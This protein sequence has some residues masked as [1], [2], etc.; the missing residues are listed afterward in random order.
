MKYNN[1]ITEFYRPIKVNSPYM[2]I[3]MIRRILLCFLVLMSFLLPLDRESFK[4]RR[5]NIRNQLGPRSAMVLLTSDIYPRNNDVDFPFRPDSDFWYVTGHPEPDAKLIMTAIDFKGKKEVPFHGEIIFAQPRNRLRERWN[6]KRLGSQGAKEELGFQY[7]AVSD[8]F[9]IILSQILPYI[10]T[11]FVNYGQSQPG[12][13]SQSSFN[14]VEDII[15]DNV[16]VLDAGSIIHPMRHIKTREEIELLQK[17]IDITGKAFIEAMVRTKPGLYEYNIEASIEFIFRDSGCQR[18]GFPSIV[19]SGPNSTILH[20]TKNDRFMEKGDLLLM[21]IGAEY[22]MYSADITRTIPVNGKFTPEQKE[23]YHYVL[24]AQRTIFDS[25]KAGMTLQDL[26]RIAKN[27]LRNKGFDRYFIHGV[28]HWLGLDVHDVGGCTTEIT[29]GSVFTIEPGIYI[30]EDDTSLPA[31]YRGIGIRIEDDVLMTDKGP[32]WL[33]AHIPK[34]I[35]K[36]E[37]I[38]RKSRYRLKKQR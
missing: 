7:F 13:K 32:V 28:G 31:P 17:A 14:Q 1:K 38:M 19:G 34:E 23:L 8:S 9:K 2:E 36:I 33:S 29:E 11:V 6:G 35:E 10:D 15:P 27:Y 22:Q 26:Q 20:Y 4:S 25:V 30:P 21:D 5:L 18:S 12:N 24:K 3:V 16:T 37:K